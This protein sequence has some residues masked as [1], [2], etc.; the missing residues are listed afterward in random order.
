M[1]NRVIRDTLQLWFAI[2]WCGRCV[3]AWEILSRSWSWSWWLMSY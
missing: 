3:C 1:T 2:Q